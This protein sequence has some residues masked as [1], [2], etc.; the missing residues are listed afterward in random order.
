MKLYQA[1]YQCHVHALQAIS[2]LF[3]SAICMLPWRQMRNTR[4]GSQGFQETSTSPLEVAR[5]AT[6]QLGISNSGRYGALGT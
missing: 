2:R 3:T 4:R 6:V 1:I 5:I